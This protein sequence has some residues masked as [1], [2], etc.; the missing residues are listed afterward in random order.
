MS[1]SACTVNGSC[2]LV[3]CVLVIAL[4]SLA[5]LIISQRH[6]SAQAIERAIAKIS[7]QFVMALRCVLSLFKTMVLNVAKRGCELQMRCQLR[8]HTLVFTVLRAPEDSAV[9]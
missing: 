3:V 9:Q 6:K 8:Q 5:R 4:R 1:A 2:L 7:L